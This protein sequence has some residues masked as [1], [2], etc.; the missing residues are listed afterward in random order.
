M[1]LAILSNKVVL[2]Q[3]LDKTLYL[4]FN[5]VCLTTEGSKY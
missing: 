5:S 2:V 1:I 3:M 4:S